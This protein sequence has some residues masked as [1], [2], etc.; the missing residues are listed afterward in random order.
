MVPLLHWESP[1]HA[2]NFPPPLCMWPITICVVDQQTRRTCSPLFH[3]PRLPLLYC[4]HGCRVIILRVPI[5]NTSIDCPPETS[6]QLYP[7]LICRLDRH[8][9]ET[10]PRTPKVHIFETTPNYNRGRDRSATR[11]PK[12]IT[13]PKGEV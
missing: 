6:V 1:R 5:S 9:A 4:N 7:T 11:T 12:P 13:F 8:L 3:H 10:S 2:T